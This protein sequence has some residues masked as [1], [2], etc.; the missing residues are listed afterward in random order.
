VA[1]LRRA[2]RQTGMADRLVTRAGGYLLVAGPE[3]VDAARFDQLA[4]QGRALLAA[5]HA[6]GAAGC[7]QEALGLWRGPPLADAGDWDWARAEAAGLREAQLAAVE[8]PPAGPA[9]LWAGG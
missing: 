6:V 9:G 1:E 2:F 8:C 7:L 5:G 3:D 4:A